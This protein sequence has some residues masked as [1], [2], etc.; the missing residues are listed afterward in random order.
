LF[1]KQLYDLPGW[2]TRFVNALLDNFTSNEDEIS[3]NELEDEFKRN[4]V[5]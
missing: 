3:E 5:A 2:D 1:W 4:A